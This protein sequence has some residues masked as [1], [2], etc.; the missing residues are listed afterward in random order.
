MKSQMIVCSVPDRRKAEAVRSSLKG[1]VTPE[2][3]ASILQKHGN[4]TVYLDRESA[5]LL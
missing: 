4:V 2:V 1:Q 3:P 5:A